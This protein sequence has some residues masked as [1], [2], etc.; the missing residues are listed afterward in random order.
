[1]RPGV[2]PRSL[3]RPSSGARSWVAELTTWARI[4]QASS[5]SWNAASGA[6]TRTTSL[7]R[8]ESSISDGSW[9]VTVTSRLPSASRVAT[10]W[11]ETCWADARSISP[12]ATGTSTE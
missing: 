7:R 5:T 10:T 9:L 1:M 12:G 2:S 6:A 4:T 8:C 11:S 3:A